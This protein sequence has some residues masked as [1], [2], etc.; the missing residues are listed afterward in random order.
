MSN[1]Y[2]SRWTLTFFG[3]PEDYKPKLWAEIFDLIY[4]SNGAITHDE[5]YSMPSVRRRFYLN[6]LAKIKEDENKKTK[7]IPKNLSKIP[8]IP[9]RKR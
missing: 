1:W 8:K 5:A 2:L 4:Y 9:L 6:Y 7:S 3:L